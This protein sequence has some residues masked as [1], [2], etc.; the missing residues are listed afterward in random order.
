MAATLLEEAEGRE[1]KLNM[2][3]KMFKTLIPK[4]DTITW[5]KYVVVAKMSGE[6]RFFALNEWYHALPASCRRSDMRL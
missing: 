4:R 1:K 2:Q 6:H 5:G 3:L